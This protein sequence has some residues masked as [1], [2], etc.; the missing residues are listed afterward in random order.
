MFEEMQSLVDGFR[1]DT[2]GFAPDTFQVCDDGID[3][4]GE[5]HDELAWGYTV[6]VAD[7]TQWIGAPYARE[8]RNG[9][10]GKNTEMFIVRQS[11]QISYCRLVRCLHLFEAEGERQVAGMAP[12]LQYSLTYTLLSE[13]QQDLDSIAA[14]L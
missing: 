7:P 2:Q 13:C 9:W 11:N 12:P 6:G 8:R 4:Q 10:S 1:I 5:Q 3:L 14:G